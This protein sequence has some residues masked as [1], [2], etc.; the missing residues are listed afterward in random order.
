MQDPAYAPALFRLTILISLRKLGS[1]LSVGWSHAAP[2]Q[3]AHL[4]VQVDSGDLREWVEAVESPTFRNEPVNDT[5]HVH[6]EG[7]LGGTGEG[8]QP[9]P[10]YLVTVLHTPSD[11]LVSQ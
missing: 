3:P 11:V 8:Q 10:V 2:M 4:R 6:V 5:T 7:Y 9:L 1:P